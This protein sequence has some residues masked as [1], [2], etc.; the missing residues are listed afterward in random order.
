MIKGN[1]WTALSTAAIMLLSL[2]AAGCSNSNNNGDTKPA[3]G[4]SSQPSASAQATAKPLS[5][6]VIDWYII[7]PGAAG[8]RAGRSRNQQDYA[9]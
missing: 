4:T 6:Y 3:T 7:G 9:A 2:T 1:K 5:P 8:R